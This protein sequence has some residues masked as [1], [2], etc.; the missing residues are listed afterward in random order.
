LP[1]PGAFGL[2]LIPHGINAALANSSKDEFILVKT[3]HKGA[4][5]LMSC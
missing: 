3:R 2:S 1:L 4:A 5:F